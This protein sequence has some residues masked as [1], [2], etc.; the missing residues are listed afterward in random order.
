MRFTV[1]VTDFRSPK[2]FKYSIGS[3]CCPTETMRLQ[4]SFR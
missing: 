2:D 3:D 4:G 1:D